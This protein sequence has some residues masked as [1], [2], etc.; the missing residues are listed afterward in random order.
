MDQIPNEL[1][2][3]VLGAVPTMILFILLVIAYG[4]LVRRPLEQILAERRAR[5]TGAMEQAKGAM[6]AAEAE[7]GAYEEKLRKA[8][9]ELFE[10]QAERRLK[11]WAAER[12]TALEQVRKIAQERVSSARQGN[13]AGRGGSQIPDRRHQRGIELA[14]ARSGD[15]GEREA[16]G[17]GAVKGLKITLKMSSVRASFCGFCCSALSHI[18]MPWCGSPRWRRRRLLP[19]RSPGRS[20]RQRSRKNTAT[21]RPFVILRRSRPWERSW[22]SIPNRRRLPLRLSISSSWL[23][24]WAGFC[25]EALPKTFRNRNAALEKHLVEAQAA[26]QEASRRLESLEARLGKLDEQIATMRSQAEKDAQGEEQRMKASVEEEKQK[27]LASA[28]QD[29]AAAAAQARRQI[30]QYA[31]GPCDRSGGAE[32][33]GNG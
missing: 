2:G 13:R 29:I 5:T 18:A 16:C 10:S 4:L 3:L 25:R 22:V 6:A 20:R 14:G 23:C 32:A 11:Q 24:L 12:E 8:K 1:G 28:E 27:I 17:G 33:G 15:A 9:A 31:A 7:T 26:S 19:K 30:Q 21:K